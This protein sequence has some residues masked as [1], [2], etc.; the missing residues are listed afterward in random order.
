MSENRRGGGIFFDSH[1]T[2]FFLGVTFLAHP[3][4]WSA[5]IDRTSQNQRPLTRLVSGFW[6]VR[7]QGQSV[8]SGWSGHQ[9]RSV[10]T[11]LQ[12]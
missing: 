6:P 9:G 8:A 11:D 2:K 12:Q 4:D 10:A 1:C 3:V 7:H 5:S